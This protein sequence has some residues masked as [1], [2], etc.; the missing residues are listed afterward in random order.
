MPVASIDRLH[1]IISGSNVI[2]E[3]TGLEVSPRMDLFLANSAGMV[4]PLFVANRG[5]R[6]DFSFGTPQ[7]KSALDI[8]GVTI[9]DLSSGNT[10]LIFRAGEDAA[11]MAAAATTSG[12]RFR[13]A[14]G[15]FEVTSVSAG[16][17][18]EASAQCRMICAYDGTNVPLVY[19]GSVATSSITPASALHYLAGP[20]FLNGTQINAIQSIQIDFG[21]QVLQIG[22]DGELYDTF[23]CEI[24]ARPTITITAINTGGWSTTGITGVAVTSGSFYFR[25]MG[26]V[27]PVADATAGHVKFA[28]TN[29]LACIENTSGDGRTP[30]MTTFKI[31]PVA[32]SATAKALVLTSTAV[33]ITS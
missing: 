30:N 8:S 7:L 10:D 26:A 29:G 3:F 17:R 32:A 6:P 18:T 19:T 5:L 11:A 25:K 2:T 31:Y 28:V 21:R 27:G 23:N 14:A 12:H 9:A 22:S 24:E 20:C 33:A 4:D 15:I 16:H 1:G 13:A